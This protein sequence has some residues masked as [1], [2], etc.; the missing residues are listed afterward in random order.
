MTELK[1]V[2][3]VHSFVRLFRSFVRFV[4]LFVKVMA[5][6]WGGKIGIS[7][8]KVSSEHRESHSSQ[9]GIKGLVG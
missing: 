2:R 5:L 7:V 4:R 8:T 1:Q 9:A 6:C 3:F